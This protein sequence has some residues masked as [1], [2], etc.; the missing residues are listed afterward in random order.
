MVDN[1]ERNVLNA[2]DVVEQGRKELVVAEK[3][4]TS[5]RKVKFNKLNKIIY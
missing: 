5:S 2:T 4:Q 1:I 3:K